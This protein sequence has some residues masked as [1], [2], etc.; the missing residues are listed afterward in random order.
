MVGKQGG[1]SSSRIGSRNQH[2]EA[3]AAVLPAFHPYPPTVER[4]EFLC[5]C[6]AESG[7]APLPRDGIV[8]LVEFLEHHF[9]LI[10]GYS[11]AAV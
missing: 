7:S 4:Y 10:I 8:H 3:A 9:L 11:D 5:D 1:S 6:E 2:V